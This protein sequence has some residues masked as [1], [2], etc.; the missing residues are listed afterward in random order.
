MLSGT[1]RFLCAEQSVS[2]HISPKPTA[3]RLLT[4]IYGRYKEL[5]TVGKIPLTTW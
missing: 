2:A 3:T 5:F 4:A 1:A